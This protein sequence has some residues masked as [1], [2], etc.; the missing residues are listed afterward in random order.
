MVRISLLTILAT[1]LLVGCSGSSRVEDIV[2][3]W[4]N[5]PPPSSTRYIA[6]RQQR[7]ARRSRKRT[8]DHKKPRRRNR[9][10]NPWLEAFL[11]SNKFRR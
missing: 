2:P 1:L 4:A 9:R 10:R 11:K 8:R 7:E 3:A 6:Q 5:T